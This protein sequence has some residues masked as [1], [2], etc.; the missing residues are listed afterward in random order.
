MK[1]QKPLV[2]LAELEALV[3]DWGASSATLPDRFYTVRL[4]FNVLVMITAALWLLLD[5]H[6]IALTLSTDPQAIER[7]QGYLY[8][9]GWFML[10]I[11][12]LGSYAYLKNWYPALAFSCCFVIGAMNLVS[13]LFT[14]Y[15]E[16]LDNPT[17]FFTVSLMVRLVL[18]WV[19]YKSVRN[20]SR[21]PDVKDRLVAFWPFRRKRAATNASN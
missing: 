12:A 5:A 8:F 20:A 7:I 14:V 18:L 10:G 21:M 3:Q 6:G 9:R 19:M 11:L 16:R 17:P 2:T 15:P 4:A 1:E 13:D